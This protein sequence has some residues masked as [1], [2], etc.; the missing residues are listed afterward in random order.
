MRALWNAATARPW[1]RHS[2]SFMAVVVVALIAIGVAAHFRS[3]S[4]NNYSRLAYSILHGHLWIDWPGRIIDAAEYHGKHYSVDAPFP[5]LFVLPLAVFY[6]E[7]ANQTLPAMLLGALDVGFGWILLGRL[8]VALV[9]RLWLTV[10]LFAGTDLWWCAM[11]GDVWFFA[12]VCAVGCTL[13]ILIELAGKRRGWLIGILAVCAFESRFTLALAVPVYAYLIAS[14]ELAREAGRATPEFAWRGALRNY[15]L[16]LAA[17]A[18]FWIAY[19]EA[20]WGLPYDIGHTLYYHQDSWGHPTGSPFQLAYL[21]YQLY[22]YFVQ[23]PVFVE[24]L[25]VAQWPYFKVDPHGVALTFTSPALILAFL[26]RARRQLIVALWV[27][28]FVTA[29]PSFLYYLNGWYQFGMRHALDFEPFLFVLMA[30]AV[31]Q[32]MPLWGA[33]LCAWSALAGTWGVWYWDSF[34]RTGD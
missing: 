17:G 11:L 8:G 4:Y 12:H 10:F 30:L 5:V 6:G 24:W 19:N 14:G 3:T 18:V 15:A 21:P 9:P 33:V 13:L 32:R 25:Q 28:V 2:A 22:S 26:A 34:F 23:G 27:A 1:V 16:V 20:L 31:R 7:A 29:G